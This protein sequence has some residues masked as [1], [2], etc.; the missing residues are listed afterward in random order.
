M[1]SRNVIFAELS[2]NPIGS[3]TTSIGKQIDEALKAIK[4]IQGLKYEAN[5]MGTLL[6]SEKLETILEAAKVAHEAVL[7]LGEK[8]VETTLKIDDRR[9]KART[10][11]RSLP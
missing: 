6:E 2:I 3:G 4:G 5:S 9:D 1:S 10:L 8:R 11:T 7:R